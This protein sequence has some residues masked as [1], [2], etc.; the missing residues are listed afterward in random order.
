MDKEAE[1]VLTQLSSLMKHA[2]FKGNIRRRDDDDKIEMIVEANDTI[3]GKVGKMLDQISG[4]LKNP[5]PS[6]ITN[7]PQQVSGSWNVNARASKFT[8]A[9]VLNEVLK[10]TKTIEKPQLNFSDKIN[11]DRNIVFEPKIKYK[12]NMLKPLAI[13]EEI[14]ES[15]K[16]RYCHPY[17]FELEHFKP[18]QEQL[19]HVELGAYKSLEETP[20][21]FVT[22]VEGV[23]SMIND[24]KK[25]KEIAVDL[26]HHSYRSFQ[27]FTCLLQISTRDTDYIVDTL[28]LR[29]DLENLN[30]VFTDP[31]VV[32]IFH[33]AESDLLWLQRDLGVY[34]V[35]MFDT[36]EA[37]KFLGYPRL[38]L[39]FLLQRFCNVDAQKHFQLADWRVRPLPE[40]LVDYAR[41]DTHY[42]L[43]IYDNLKN[44]LIEKGNGKTNCLE[45]VISS[46]TAKCIS[47][48][49]EMPVWNEDGYLDLY[50]RS[51]K[52][53]DNR[54]KYAM[55][56]LYEWRDSAART[57]DE[58]YA[59]VLPNHMLLQISEALPREAQGILACC[60]P[61]PP[62]VRKH[63]LELHQLI[64]KAREQPLVEPVFEE[65]RFYRATEENN[66]TNDRLRCPHDLNY[67][68][69]FRD[70][71]PVLISNNTNTIDRGEQLVAV[72][73]IVNVFEKSAVRPNKSLPNLNK[74]ALLTPYQR[75]KLTKPFNETVAAK[76]AEAQMIITSNKEKI[77]MMEIDTVQ[78]LLKKEPEEPVESLRKRKREDGEEGNQAKKIKKEKSDLMK[79]PFHDK[80][81]NSKQDEAPKIKEEKPRPEIKPFNYSSVDYKKYQT[82]IDSDSKKNGANQ[83][84]MKKFGKKRN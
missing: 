23:E 77:Q 49:Y 78:S 1:K 20:F 11:N 36:Y 26:E 56:S 42:L 18:P 15:G 57:Y 44:I 60:N 6:L 52:L 76:E 67:E 74:A 22:T 30:E 81:A 14:D 80:N 9:Q 41:S 25:Y 31:K 47:Q 21:H 5:E 69:E 19:K 48:V 43:Y 39:A 32:K 24:L 62:L 8:A 59:Y 61:V 55:K 13:T 65:R 12:H 38:S 33:G 50:H 3:L 4:V 34:V 73:P 70:D 68:G 28:I 29:N 27:G 84:K 53:F 46:S 72:K 40:S 7:V 71:L 17:Q 83:R 45:S 58:S 82:Y 51:K 35:N 75:Y 16:I 37:S 64:L 2:G 63:L 66:L 10:K 54:Q 79:N